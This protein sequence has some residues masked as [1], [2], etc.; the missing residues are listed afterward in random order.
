MGMTL[1]YYKNFVLKSSR[2]TFTFP[3]SPPRINQTPS[4]ISDKRFAQKSFDGFD[5]DVEASNM[6]LPFRSPLFTF[7]SSSNA[8]N[9]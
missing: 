8:W 1:F 9:D 6:D 5:R 3:D 2:I 7:S 4:I